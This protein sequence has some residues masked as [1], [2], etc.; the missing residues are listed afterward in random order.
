MMTYSRQGCMD[1]F[2]LQM[3]FMAYAFI[4]ENVVLLMKQVVRFQLALT[5][6]GWCLQV[7][8]LALVSCH[9]T[10]ILYVLTKK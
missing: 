7:F 5:V 2:L 8:Q 10:P 4:S 9:F 6:G 1:Y 3:A